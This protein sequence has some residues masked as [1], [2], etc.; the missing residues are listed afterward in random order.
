MG[1]KANGNT[2][3]MMEF[4]TLLT[5]EPEN[6]YDFINENADRF[7]KDEIVNILEEVLYSIRSHANYACCDCEL[8]KNI[9][10]DVKFELQEKYSE[11]YK[12]YIK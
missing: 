10:E 12:E 3:V 11:T 5:C 2:F 6:A 4:I 7:T 8:Y 9:F 1:D